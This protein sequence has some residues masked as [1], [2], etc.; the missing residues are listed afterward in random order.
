MTRT[1]DIERVLEHWLSEGPMHMSDRLFDGTLERI[2]R[3][4]KHR[5]ADLRLRLPAMNLNI[6]LAAAAAV[7]VALVGAGLVVL[8]GLP[9][10]GSQPSPTPSAATPLGATLPS[11]SDLL[12]RWI[13]ASPRPIDNGSGSGTVTWEMQIDPD[14]FALGTPF[15]SSG[16]NTITGPWSIPEAGT[17]NLGLWSRPTDWPCGLGDPGVYDVRLSNEVLTIR[18]RSDQCQPRPEMLLGDWV[19]NALPAPTTEPQMAQR[20]V[21]PGFRPFGLGAS[22]TFSASVPLP[23]SPLQQTTSI[24]LDNPFGLDQFIYSSIYVVSGIL[25]GTEPQAASCAAPFSAPERTP[26]ALAAWIQGFASLEVSSPKPVTIGGL[27]GLM[28]DVTE[29]PNTSKTCGVPRDNGVRIEVLGD[30][31]WV[32]PGSRL[33][34]I[35]LDRGDGESILIDIGTVDEPTWDSVDAAM[36]IVNDFEFIR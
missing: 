18:L 6:R 25:P 4:P 10:V 16:R 29:R 22:G 19:R 26:A 15:A 14:L 5:L 12:G 24:Q 17:M 9:G 30:G 34:L 8:N 36:S 2:D 33:R 20:Y 28:I 11:S 23:G 32:Y 1:D 21:A 7:L 27:S 13:V 31:S 35:L 3:L